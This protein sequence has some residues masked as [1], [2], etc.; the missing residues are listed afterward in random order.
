MMVALFSGY[1]NSLHRRFFGS[2]HRLHCPPF[3]SLRV[4]PF[5]SLKASHLLLQCRQNLL[6]TVPCYRCRLKGR[7][8]S[9]YCRVH[10]ETSQILLLYGAGVAL[11]HQGLS[12]FP[13]LLTYGSSF[14]QQPCPSSWHI[15]SFKVSQVSSGLEHTL[16]QTFS[17]IKLFEWCFYEG[18][19]S[20]VVVWQIPESFYSI[21]FSYVLLLMSLSYHNHFDSGISSLISVLLWLLGICIS[22]GRCN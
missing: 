1:V 14:H 18:L 5:H 12:L 2:F 22:R 13:Q 16:V 15:L 4:A 19:V 3:H 9:F 11:F 8:L 21:K 17:S 7:R 10:I 6:P 20:L